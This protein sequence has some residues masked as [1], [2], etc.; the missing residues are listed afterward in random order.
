MQIRSVLKSTQVHYLKSV[1]RINP[2]SHTHMHSIN[3]RFH[4]YI[5]C[6]C[7]KSKWPPNPRWLP[8]FSRIVFL[9]ST[10]VYNFKSV[11]RINPKLHTHMNSI[12]TR[13]PV[14]IFAFPKT[15][16]GRQIQNGYCFL[17]KLPF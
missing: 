9:T 5:F 11:Y 1:Y 13:F 15:Q 3:A 17:A 10:N 14:Y 12:H 16:N 8:F 6:V 2:K 7:K 4:V